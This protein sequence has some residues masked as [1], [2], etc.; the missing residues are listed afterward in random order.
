MALNT[1]IE[2]FCNA[3]NEVYKDHLLKCALHNKGSRYCLQE[4]FTPTYLINK[5]YKVYSILCL[6]GGGGVRKNSSSLVLFCC[7]HLT[8]V[9]FNG[10]SLKQ[11]QALTFCVTLGHSPLCASLLLPLFV[12][13][14]KC[15]A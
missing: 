4:F 8:A 6:K 2:V 11:I 14:F 9:Q 7:F 3:V 5:A 12:V 13:S 15:T 1:L 10:R